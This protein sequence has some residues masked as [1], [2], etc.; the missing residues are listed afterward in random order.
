MKRECAFTIEQ[1]LI[2]Y[3]PEE[4][5]RWKQGDPEVV[6]PEVLLWRDSV[7]EMVMAMQS[8]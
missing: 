1:V 8:T 6:P 2:H 3:E 5:E 7:V 4:L